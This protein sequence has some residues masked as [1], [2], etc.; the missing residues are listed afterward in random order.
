MYVDVGKQSNLRKYEEEQS[1]VYKIDLSK[2]N[3][4]VFKNKFILGEFTKQLLKQE[5]IVCK[6]EKDIIPI[7]L[8][9]SENLKNSN[10]KDATVETWKEK[11]K[12]IIESFSA[13]FKIEIIQ[14]TNDPIQVI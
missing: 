5:L 11:L 7:K 2:E 14:A 8:T 9:V 1:P 3:N 6:R 10:D 13:K 4:H 12:N